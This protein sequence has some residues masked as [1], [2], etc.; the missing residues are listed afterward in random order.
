MNI[1]NSNNINPFRPSASRTHHNDGMELDDNKSEDT[2][3][4]RTP[5][6]PSNSISGLN[7]LMG[8]SSMLQLHGSLYRSNEESR[9]G[10]PTCL[11][12]NMIAPPMNAFPAPT[13]SH[14]GFP[15]PSGSSF[16]A[17]QRHQSSNPQIPP[18]GDPHARFTD[19]QTVQ[20]GTSGFSFKSNQTAQTTTSGF[21]FKDP[22]APAVQVEKNEDNT[23][24]IVETSAL[25]TTDPPSLTTQDAKRIFKATIRAITTYRD[26]LP[27][28]FLKEN[29]LAKLRNEMDG[30]VT[31]LEQQASHE[32]KRYRCNNSQFDISDIK[33]TL[34]NLERKSKE[35]IYT[36]TS[37]DDTV[38][39]LSTEYELSLEGLKPLPPRNK[40]IRCKQTN[41]PFAPIDAIRMKMELQRVQ[42]LMRGDWEKQDN[43][44]TVLKERELKRHRKDLNN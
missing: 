40:K 28:V 16:S 15:S 3:W 1:F 26:W 32:K 11:S 17:N 22:F 41:I 36:L 12:G 8:G 33:K 19:N 24:N 38:S 9:K 6:T 39:S 44:D 25:T 31:Q 42:K 18:F 23:S 43:E 13:A 30:L 10:S 2:C 37:L 29:H 14:M 34:K 20:I 7:G 5:E 4:A 21:V 27:I 35:Y